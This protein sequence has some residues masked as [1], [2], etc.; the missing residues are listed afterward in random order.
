MRQSKRT[1]GAGLQGV[2][3]D[4]CNHGQENDQ[5]RNDGEQGGE[6]G[7]RPHLLFGNLPKRLAVAAHRSEENDKILDTPPDN[8]TDQNPESPRQVAELGRQ[9]GADQGTGA[10]DG[11]KMVPQ[12]NPFVGRHIIPPVIDPLRRRGPPVVQ[13][14][15]PERQKTA[16]KPVADQVNADGGHNQPDGVDRLITIQCHGSER[17]GAGDADGNPH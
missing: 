13:F 12:E 2:G 14:E 16:V 5:N 1:P 10:G 15:H 17:T 7:D 3:H 11:G 6:T 4:E 8:G 9:G